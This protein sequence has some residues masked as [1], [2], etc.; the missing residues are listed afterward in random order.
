MLFRSLRQA[1]HRGLKRNGKSLFHNAPD[2]RR[3]QFTDIIQEL[4]G[5]GQKVH[6]VSIPS[7]WFDIHS[8]E[9]YRKAWQEVKA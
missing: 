1:Y 6:A 9:D 5:R 7:G 8:F 4:V 3:A 2:F